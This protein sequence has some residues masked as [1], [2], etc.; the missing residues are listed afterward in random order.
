MRFGRKKIPTEAPH[1]RKGASESGGGEVQGTLRRAEAL[2]NVRRLEI[3]TRGFVDSV[4]SGE[5]ASAFLGRGF[6]FSH[7][8]PYQPGDD[9]RTIDWRV[10]ARRGIPHVRQFVEERDLPV[11]LVIDIS[12]SGHFNPGRR[13][14]HLSACEVAAALTFAAVRTNDRVSMLLVSDKVEKIIPSGSGLRHAVR[15]LE[16]LL[17]HTPE[18]RGTDISAAL[19][20]VDRTVR[21][22]A[23]VFVL[24]DFEQKVRTPRFREAATRVGH[25]HDLIALRFASPKVV[26]LPDVGWLQMT[27]PESG[28]R[29]LLDTSSARIRQRYRSRTLESRSDLS[30]AISEGGGDLLDLPISDDPL[31]VLAEYFRNRRRSGR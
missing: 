9:V 23:V 13:S 27:D 18:S 6:E 17:S 19:E 12:A 22:H 7:V 29:V 4:F 24:S 5:H 26:E 20:S 2:A 14:T 3:R 16:Q 11:V 10:T 25:R 21:D 30:N 1:R 31:P 28:R 8:R 15:L